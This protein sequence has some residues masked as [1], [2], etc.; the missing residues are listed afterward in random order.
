MGIHQLRFGTE[1]GTREYALTPPEDS[2]AHNE[3]IAA[4]LTIAVASQLERTP[5]DRGEAEW[6]VDQFNV[7]YGLLTA[8]TEV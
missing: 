8:E 1:F 5:G 6:A 2:I 7:I 3:L 4:L